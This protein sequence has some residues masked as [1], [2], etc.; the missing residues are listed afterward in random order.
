[1]IYTAADHKKLVEESLSILKAVNDEVSELDPPFVVVGDVG[2]TELKSFWYKVRCKIDGEFLLLC[3]P[4]KNLRV[5]LENH[6]HGFTHTKCLEAKCSMNKTS[7]PSATLSGKRGRPS[8]RSKATV[9]NQPD[10][11]GWFRTPSSQSLG[12]INNDQAGK[13][14]SILSMLC[15][16]YW[17]RTTQYGGKYYK[18]D[19]MLG[20]PK[21]GSCWTA[22]PITSC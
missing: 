15:W 5:N 14:D 1:M 2:V 11:H 4:K 18:V 9:G 16:G 13:S 3:P 12:S 6:L 17:K 22:E 8:T 10:L 7:S 19:G 20:D 21:P